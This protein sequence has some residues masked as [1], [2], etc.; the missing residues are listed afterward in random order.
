M[1][2]NIEVARQQLAERIGNDVKLT[3]TTPSGARVLEALSER[4]VN[5][6]L[7][8]ATPEE[9]A[10]NLGCR[11]VVMWMQRMTKLAEKV[12]RTGRK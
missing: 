5:G 4:F 8:G 6:D 11:E 12:E 10:F 7:L 3:F 2:S 9:T 1:P